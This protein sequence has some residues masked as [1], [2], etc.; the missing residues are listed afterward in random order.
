MTHFREYWYRKTIH[1]IE[2]GLDP[3]GFCF[4]NDFS[5]HEQV[6]FAGASGRCSFSTALIQVD[7]AGVNTEA[8]EEVAPELLVMA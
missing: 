1:E 4:T 5:G 6:D 3:K 7:V 8:V 2:F